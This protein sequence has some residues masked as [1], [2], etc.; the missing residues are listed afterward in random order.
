VGAVKR[1]LQVEQ[2]VTWS[3]AWSITLDGVPLS[4]EDGWLARSQVRAKITDP[5]VLHQFTANLTGSV[6]QLSVMPDESSAW[7]WRRG[8]Y[9][10]EIYDAED[11]SRVVRIVQGS[12]AVSPEV[13]R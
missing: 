4:S 3:T 9:D 1:D 5:L 7:T 12:I 11:P 2:G 6:V 8:V 13:T 10:V